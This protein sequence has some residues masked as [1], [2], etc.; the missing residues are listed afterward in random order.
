[1][2]NEKDQLKVLAETQYYKD[3]RVISELRERELSGNAGTN[4]EAVTAS[5]ATEEEVNSLI[6]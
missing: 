2:K 5:P 6:A 1:L 4:A 3:Q